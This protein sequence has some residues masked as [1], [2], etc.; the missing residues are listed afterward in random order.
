MSESFTTYFQ[1]QTLTLELDGA[2]EE[3]TLSELVNQNKTL[4]A[5]PPDCSELSTNLIAGENCRLSEDGKTVTAVVTGYPSLHKNTTDEN[6]IVRVEVIPL[7]TVSDDKMSATLTLYPG[8]SGGGGLSLNDIVEYCSEREI[9]YGIDEVSI[10]ET[11]D[12]IAETKQ[13]QIDIPIARGVLPVDGRDAFLRFE[14][15]IGPL[16]GKILQDGS[17]DWRE[18]KIFIGIDKGELIATK[19]PLSQGTAGSDVLS[20]PIVQ[21]PGKDIKVKVTGDV[22]YIEENQQVVATKS[23]VLTIVNEKDIKVSAKQTIDG[24]VD[25]STGN[26]EANDCLEIK[27]DVRQGFTVFCVGD[28]SIGRNV[29][30]AKIHTKGNSKILGGLLGDNSRLVAEGDTEISFVEKGTV[31]SGGTVIISKGAYYANISSNKKI[32]CRNDSKI[33]GGTI[34]AGYDFIGGNVGSHNAAPTLIAAGVDPYR[35]DLKDRLSHEIHNE[36]NRIKNL[37]KQY[38]DKYIETTDYKEQKTALQ[39]QINTLSRLNLIKGSP[40][41]SKQD[42]AHKYCPAVIEIYGRVAAGTKIRIGNTTT[43][44]TEESAAIRFHINRLTGYIDATSTAGGSR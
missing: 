10:K 9:T 21:K 8:F 7:I 27:R 42:P 29:I 19:I 31:K 12:L 6:T 39:K 35:I 11:I 41:Y 16:P 1:S 24:D 36:E 30:N 25:F 4:V 34:Y 17:I 38:G 26:I 28:L 44:V 18:R 2:P 20:L 5:L 40:L 3:F 13:P 32:M 22:Q 14:V 15:D 43:T 23:G 37:Q 33:V